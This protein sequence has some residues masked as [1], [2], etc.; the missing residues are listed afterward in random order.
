[1]TGALFSDF[2][3]LFSKDK[4]RHPLKGFIELVLIDFGPERNLYT[5]KGCSEKKSQNQHQPRLNNIVVSN[6]SIVLTA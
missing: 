3:A 6:R 4:L 1:M 5:G 2:C